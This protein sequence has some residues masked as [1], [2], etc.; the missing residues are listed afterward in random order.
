MSK[1]SKTSELQLKQ[2]SIETYPRFQQCFHPLNQLGNEIVKDIKEREGSKFMQWSRTKSG[3]YH[4]RWN[5]TSSCDYRNWPFRCKI[6]WL[7]G[8]FRFSPQL[9]GKRKA[10]LHGPSRPLSSMWYYWLYKKWSPRAVS[11]EYG[12]TELFLFPQEAVMDV[13]LFCLHAWTPLLWVNQ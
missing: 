8:W 6:G 3:C 1:S 13:G 12:L 5:G 10:I 4:L 7:R 2:N 11:Q 9:K